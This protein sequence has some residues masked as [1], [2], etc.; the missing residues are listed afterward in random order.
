M[1]AG[2]LLGGFVMAVVVVLRDV[3]DETI[4]SPEDVEKYLQLDILTIIP[5][6]QVEGMTSG[7]EQE[8]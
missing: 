3:L 2:I 7:D 8:V 5:F 6:S 1:I 4:R